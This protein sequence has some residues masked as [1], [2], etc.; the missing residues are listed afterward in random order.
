[1][2]INPKAAL[3]S[4]VLTSS[5]LTAIQVIFENL[6]RYDKVPNLVYTFKVVF[7]SKYTPHFSQCPKIFW[8]YASMYET[9]IACDSACDFIF[10]KDRSRTVLNQANLSWMGNDSL[11]IFDQKWPYVGELCNGALS[12][13]PSS[14]R[15]VLVL[16]L[17]CLHFFGLGEPGCF[18]WLNF[19]LGSWSYPKIQ[20]SS[21][22]MIL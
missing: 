21:P 16:V 9:S 8:P 18:H 12:W 17:I 3:N 20:L 5:S 22:S 14:M 13:Y 2:Y 7:H 6:S 1:M 15:M 11:R 10:G 19:W 4:A